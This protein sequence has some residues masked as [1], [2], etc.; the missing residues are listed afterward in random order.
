MKFKEYQF[1]FAD[2]AK[3]YTI[4]P[5]I[6]EKAFFDPRGIIDQL[7][8]RWAFMLV[9][10]KGVG[11]SAFS[12]KILSLSEENDNLYSTQMMLNDFEFSTF[13]KTKIDSNVNGTQKYKSSW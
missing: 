11:K 13:S 1:G 5:E 9:G 10:R 7:M 2:A 4:F 12:S 8:N 3:E 6:F